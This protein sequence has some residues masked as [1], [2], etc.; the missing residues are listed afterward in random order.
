MG[1]YVIKSIKTSYVF[2]TKG[3]DALNS[4]YATKLNHKGS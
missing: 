2:S 3:Y 1:L 4:G